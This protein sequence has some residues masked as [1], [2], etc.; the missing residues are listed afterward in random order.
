MAIFKWDNRA[1]SG[2]QSNVKTDLPIEQKHDAPHI[3]GLSTGP[4]P[5]AVAEAVERIGASHAMVVKVGFRN[6][7]DALKIFALECLLKRFVHH[8]MPFV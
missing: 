5:S 2:I 6:F 8:A 4:G 7:P 1:R 3:Y